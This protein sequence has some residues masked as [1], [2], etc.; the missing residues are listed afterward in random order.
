MAPARHEGELAGREGQVRHDRL[1]GDLDLERVADAPGGVRRH[2]EVAAVVQGHLD[3]PT[4][5][6]VLEPDAPDLRRRLVRGDRHEDEL[7]AAVLQH[8]EMLVERGGEADRVHEPDAPRWVL[9]DLPVDE[10]VSLAEEESDLACGRG[11]LAQVSNH[12]QYGYRLELRV[13]AG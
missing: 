4:A 6:G 3:L 5:D 10:D 8:A 13:G 11:D 7:A 12:D 1:V 2:Q 9:Y